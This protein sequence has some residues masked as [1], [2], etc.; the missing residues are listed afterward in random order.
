M[1]DRVFF[2][3]QLHLPGCPRL[4]GVDARPAT[5]ADHEHAQACPSCRDG[6]SQY[7]SHERGDVRNND[8]L[9]TDGGVELRDGESRDDNAHAQQTEVVREDLD[10]RLKFTDLPES[11]QTV[12]E[13][14]VAAGG[15]LTASEAKTLVATET[16]LTKDGVQHA[17]ERLTEKAL[18]ERPPLMTD[19][20]QTKWVLTDKGRSWVRAGGDA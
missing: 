14:L 8:H 1:T 10:R 13:V 19:V 15:W 20:R 9:L 4:E 17:G 5:P 6:T 12:L 3:G 7:Q 11:E 18:I 2:D 16:G